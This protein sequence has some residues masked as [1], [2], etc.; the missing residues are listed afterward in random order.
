MEA[1][2]IGTTVAWP[3]GKPSAVALAA[4]LRDTVSLTGQSDEA[5][6]FRDGLGFIHD[7]TNDR[8]GYAA[9]G[10][11][12]IMNVGVLASNP[13]LMLAGVLISGG[14]VVAMLLRSLPRLPHEKGAPQQP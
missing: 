1:I 7:R 6:K 9:L 11:L 14:S 8:L 12:V 4:S 10:G 13:P 5:P 3:A 2:Q